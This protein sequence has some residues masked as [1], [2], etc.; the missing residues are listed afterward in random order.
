MNKRKKPKEIEKQTEERIRGVGIKR[1]IR[2][3]RA[4]SL[5]GTSGRKERDFRARFDRS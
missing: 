5:E 4:V 2:Q 1:F 3:G